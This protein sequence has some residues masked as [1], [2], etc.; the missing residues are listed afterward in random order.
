MKAFQGFGRKKTRAHLF[1]GSKGYFWDQ[2]ERTRERE[3]D[4]WI[5]NTGEKVRFPCCGRSS[6][7]NLSSFEFGPERNNQSQTLHRLRRPCF[8]STCM[9]R[10]EA[11]LGVDHVT[12]IFIGEGVGGERFYKNIN[13]ASIVLPKIKCAHS[14]CRKKKKFAHV[15]WP[16]NAG[17]T[18]QKHTCFEK[19]NSEWMKGLNKNRACTLSPNPSPKLSTPFQGENLPAWKFF[20]SGYLFPIQWGKWCGWWWCVGNSAFFAMWTIQWKLRQLRKEDQME[21]KNPAR[22]LYTLCGC[23][24]GK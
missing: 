1:Q 6:I 18:E 22:N 21:R 12:Y 7:T 17:Y 11:T 3:S 8:T 4:Q 5:R 14:H 20:S 19:K 10:E 24:G 2:L 15:Q 9:A 23:H 16:E 13:P